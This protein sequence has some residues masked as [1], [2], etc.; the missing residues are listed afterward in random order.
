M[1]FTLQDV[2][3]G[4]GDNWKWPS[5]CQAAGRQPLFSHHLH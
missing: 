3:V 2:G 5:R 1:P 4:V